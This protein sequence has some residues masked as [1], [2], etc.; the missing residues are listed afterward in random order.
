ME[1]TD[2]P[3]H[4]QVS[5]YLKMFLLSLQHIYCRPLIR[6]VVALPLFFPFL[7]YKL[8]I[9]LWPFTCKFTS[10]HPSIAWVHDIQLLRPNYTARVF[11][12]SEF[13]HKK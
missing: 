13:W 11:V 5:A 8:K 9:F 12:F 7:T 4:Y 6:K 1:I 3:A 10:K 2:G